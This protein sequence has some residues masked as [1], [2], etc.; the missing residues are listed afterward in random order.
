MHHCHRGTLESQA[1]TL[2]SVADWKQE[3]VCLLHIICKATILLDITLQERRW[4]ARPR[5]KDNQT[6]TQLNL[7]STLCFLFTE[8]CTAFSLLQLF[9]L[10]VMWN[11]KINVSLFDGKPLATNKACVVLRVIHVTFHKTCTL[12]IWTDTT[13][14]TPVLYKGSYSNI[15]NA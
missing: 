12:V 13:N 7:P 11:W 10:D 4:R 3:G 8:E 14:T 9:I 15:Y 5:D 6:S 2:H 1:C